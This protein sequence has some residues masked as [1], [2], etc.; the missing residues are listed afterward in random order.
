MK[1]SLAV[2]TASALAL[3]AGV[4]FTPATHAMAAPARPAADEVG[5][6]YKK[7]MDTVG[8]ALVTVKFV[9]KFDGG[10][11][12]GD[13]AGRD[14]E[15]TGLMM[16]AGGLVLVSNAKMGG[17]ASRMGMTANPTSI[18]VLIGDDTEGL[19]AKILARDSDLDLCWIQV[20]DEKGKGKTFTAVDFA[21]S[22]TA[23]VGDKLFVVERMG[24]F[25]D[26][27]LSVDE[28]RVGGNTKKPRPL[29]IP[30]G[31]GGSQREMLGAPMFGADGKVVGWN[32]LQMPDKED[33]EGGEQ[34]GEGSFGILLLPAA[35][36]VK[37]TVRGKEMAAKNPPKAEE[38][39][40]AEDKKDEKAEKPATPTPPAE[41]KPEAPK[42]P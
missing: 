3:A 2:L 20:D 9:M 31:F 30:A 18:K 33:M 13:E 39:K 1:R 21:A 37:A 41:K 26:H 19:K 38:E 23:A 27:A 35:E 17:M 6:T 32:I 42:K 40:K 5:A 25:F 29:M 15:T 7:L 12:G 34:G 14:V 10:P 16:E 4:C 24:K 8:P 28:G 22:T 36:V 11:M